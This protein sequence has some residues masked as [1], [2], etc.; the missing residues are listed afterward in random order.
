MAQ[1]NTD[2]EW[3]SCINIIL[4]L[5]TGYRRS[6]CRHSLLAYSFIF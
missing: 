4:K 6:E 1:I 5:G 3:C 2:F